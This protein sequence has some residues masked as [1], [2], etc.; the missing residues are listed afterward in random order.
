MQLSFNRICF[1]AIIVFFFI[2][3]KLTILFFKKRKQIEDEIIEEKIRVI[4]SEE[5]M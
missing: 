5:L 2:K 3:L 1:H 4:G